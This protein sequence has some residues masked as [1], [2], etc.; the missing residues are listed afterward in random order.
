MKGVFSGVSTYKLP[1][2]L[3]DCVAP[4]ESTMFLSLTPINSLAYKVGLG[5]S[6]FFGLLVPSLPI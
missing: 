1:R 6:P 4:F 2:G 3:P 5:W